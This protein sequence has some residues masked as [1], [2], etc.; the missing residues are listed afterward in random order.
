MKRGQSPTVRQRELATQ[1]RRLRTEAGL[2]VAE[3]AKAL[4]C[5]PTKVSRI[6][7]GH[8]SA[9]LRDVRDLCDLYRITDP[10]QREHLM[11]LAREAK[12]RAWWQEGE[13][14]YSAFVGLETEATSIIDYD[15]AVVP[16]LLQTADY[17]RA[18]EEAGVPPLGPDRVKRNIEARLTRQK[19]LTQDDPP[20]FRAILDEAVL[21]RKVGGADVMRA[22]LQHVIEMTDLP[23]VT[24]Q[25]I[26]YDLGAHPALDSTFTILDFGNPDLSDVVY[27]E[28]LIGFVFLERPH[29][30]EKYR[31]VAEYLRDRALSPEGSV[32]LI[33][34]VADALGR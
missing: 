28:G 10:D 6:E 27:V 13:V 33:A 2:S 4:L 9:S 29:D 23:N 11:T 16:G 26:P 18:I 24:V 3:V 14:P 8:R 12:Q 22:Q 17:A 21:H 30:L 7:T 25:V 5:S 15:S 31:Q 34:K 1:L 19:I 20:R 32:D